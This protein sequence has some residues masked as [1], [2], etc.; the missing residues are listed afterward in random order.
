VNCA[1]GPAMARYHSRTPVVIEP[2]EFSA[3]L[4][5]AADPQRLI[6]PPADDMFTVTRVTT[7]V[8]KPAHDDP[9]CF[10][11]AGDE[12]PPT[13]PEKARRAKKA[14]PVDTRQSSLF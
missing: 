10:A 9:Q 5:P 4:D 8:N 7:Y 1:S 2:D 14:K 3:W 13:P 12:K 6:K 11:P